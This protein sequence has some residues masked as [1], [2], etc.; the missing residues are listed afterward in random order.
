MRCPIPTRVWVISDKSRVR[1]RGRW[2]KARVRSIPHEC[3]SIAPLIALGQLARRCIETP[4]PAEKNAVRR[5]TG[6]LR[7]LLRRRL[8]QAAVSTGNPGTGSYELPV[9]KCNAAG[10]HTVDTVS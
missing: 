7:R 5:Q 3:A 9:E 6:M 8:Q 1:A 2:N 10:T 4:V